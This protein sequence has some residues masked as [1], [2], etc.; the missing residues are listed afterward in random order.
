MVARV[1][2][3]ALRVYI[4]YKSDFANEAVVCDEY[5]FIAFHFLKFFLLLDILYLPNLMFL[6]QFKVF[7]ILN[8][9]SPIIF[10]YI[11]SLFCNYCV[12]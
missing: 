12:S 3:S 4:L 9:F 10:I 1:C 5:L 11:G 8:Q 7:E 6:S 2:T